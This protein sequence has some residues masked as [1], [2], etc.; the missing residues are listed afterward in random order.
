MSLETPTQ[1]PE[2]QQSDRTIPQYVNEH[3]LA[4]M[5]NCSVQKLRNDR[6]QRRGRAYAKLGSSVRYN[7]QDVLD[8]FEARKIRPEQSR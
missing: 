4:G 2:K 7:L 6:S 8:H 3:Q 1:R 5:F